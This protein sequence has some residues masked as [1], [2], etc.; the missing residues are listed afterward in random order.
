MCVSAGLGPVASCCH[1]NLHFRQRWPSGG[2]Y[3]QPVGS[4]PPSS[5][6]SGQNKAAL[7]GNASRR[8]KAADTRGSPLHLCPCPPPSRKLPGSPSESPSS[9]RSSLRAHTA[10]RSHRRVL[11][12]PRAAS[13][14][15]GR[16]EPRCGAVRP[17]LLLP[18]WRGP[19]SPAVRGAL[20]A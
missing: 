9:P 12:P 8:G 3:G 11:T 13:E 10:A 14:G 2:L 4:G 16:Q 7:G 19:C 18:P 1:P 20:R 5:C 6:H 15:C 17:A